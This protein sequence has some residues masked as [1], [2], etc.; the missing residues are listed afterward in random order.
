MSGDAGVALDWLGSVAAAVGVISSGVF[1]WE[2]AS[3]EIS[4]TSG[5]SVKVALGRKGVLVRVLRLMVLGA[6]GRSKQ[7]LIR[8]SS[9]MKT[10]VSSHVAG[11]ANRLPGFI[12]FRDYTN[13]QIWPG[14]YLNV[15]YSGKNHQ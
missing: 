4:S 11:R 10:A 3:R 14:F 1:V 9:R 7:P 6:S 12:T 15:S 8:V 13:K 2:G 5:V